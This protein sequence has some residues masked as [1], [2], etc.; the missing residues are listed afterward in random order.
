[1]NDIAA[2][3]H[4]EMTAGEAWTAD[5]APRTAQQVSVEVACAGR[6]AGIRA[7]RTGRLGRAPEPNV[8]MDP[9]VLAATHDADP[10]G[11]HRA[12]LAWTD[13]DGRKQLTGL[14]AFSVGRARR[15][16]LPMSVVRVPSFTQSYLATPV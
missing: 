1:M 5:A 9:D 13:I 8:F 10:E 6:L 16:M 2:I 4:S 12:L 15:S 11:R 14:W 3:G 7:D